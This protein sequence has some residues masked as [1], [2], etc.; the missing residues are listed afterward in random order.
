MK[1]HPECIP[2]L[3][4][5]AKFECDLAFGS[6]EQGK[7]EAMVEIA[8]YASEKIDGETVPALIGTHRGRIISKMSGVEDPYERLKDESNRT[9]KEIL[10]AAIDFYEKA[11]DRVF[12]LLKIAAAANS[13]EYGVRGHIFNER[14]FREEFLEILEEDVIGGV[15]LAETALKDFSK[16]LYLLDNA[17]EVVLDRFV[18]GELEKQGKEVV[19]SPKSRPVINDITE[20]ELADLGFDMN[21]VISSGSYVGI[22]LE[23]A[24]EDFLKI[25]FNPEYLIIAKG[26]GNYET[27]SEYENQ[28]KGRLLYIFRAKCLSVAE[29]V[30][31][32]KGTLV[33]THV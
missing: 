1:I 25:L 13:M 33:I 27:L 7:L 19:V 5:R 29:S 12:A 8:K 24:P 10:P 30:G 26:M 31:V 14:K 17:G 3:F 15:D 4:D 21:K 20:R 11:E 16:I 9:G 22:S 18:I 32:K 23:E 6:N 2:C 28:F